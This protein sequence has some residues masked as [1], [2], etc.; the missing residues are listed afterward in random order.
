[1]KDLEIQDFK[2]QKVY[3]MV[4]QGEDQEVQLEDQQVD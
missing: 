4:I 2:E 1:M 3:Q